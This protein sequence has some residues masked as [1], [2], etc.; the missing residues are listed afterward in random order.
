MADILVEFSLSIEGFLTLTPP[1]GVIPCEYPDKLYLS[2]N[3]GD[4]PYQML[5]TSRSPFLWTKHGN[6]TEGQTDRQTEMV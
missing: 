2:K 4:C 5:I 3:Q 1:L 6:V